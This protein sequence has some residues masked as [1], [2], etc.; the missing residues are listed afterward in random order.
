MLSIS[1]KDFEEKVDS[2]GVVQD[3]TLSEFAL[4]QLHVKEVL[5]ADKINIHL[6]YN[7]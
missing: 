3:M 1:N 6:I 2:M 7:Q 5:C 4:L